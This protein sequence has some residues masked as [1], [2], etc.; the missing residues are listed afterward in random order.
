MKV[1]VTGGAGFIGSH[2]VEALLRAHYQVFVID[3]LSS[4]K[5][6]QVPAPALF[7]KLDIRS[8]KLQQ[9]LVRLKPDYICHLAA[10][11]SV[12]RSH[13]DV[14]FDASVNIV[15]SINILEAI[16][17]LELKKF[18][19][20]S[21]GAVYGDPREIPTPETSEFQLT[22]PYA[23]S[24]HTLEN[25]LNYFSREYGVANVVVRPANVYGPRQVHDAEG[26]VVAQFSRNLLTSGTVTIEGKGDQTRDFIYVGDVAA[27]IIAAMVKGSGVYNLSTARDVSI[28]ELL[29]EMGKVANIIPQVNYAP[30]RPA[31]IKRSALSPRRAEREL[32]WKPQ[33]PLVDGLGLTIRWFKDNLKV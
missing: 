13:Q 22:S 24:K 26:G 17:N 28:R 21:T 7:Y 27:G 8:P 2:L 25:Y 14:A 11:K 33:V 30:P 16:K 4:G 1:L 10:Q 6:S 32:D 19:F 9:L 3:D 20:V 29:V 23:L 12:A 5:R 15:G 31:D 18:L